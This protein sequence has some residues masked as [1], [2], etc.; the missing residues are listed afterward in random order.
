MNLINRAIPASP[1]RNE[2][3]RSRSSA[4]LQGVA[5]TEARRRYAE[6]LAVQEDVL[7]P[8]HPQTP[9]T[10]THLAAELLGAGECGVAQCVLEEVLR[11]SRR[12]DSRPRRELEA[13]PRLAIE[14]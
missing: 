7:G 14:D 5:T 1:V 13:A 9:V 3:R 4:P 12:T 11:M 10:K 6:V 2:E 8:Q